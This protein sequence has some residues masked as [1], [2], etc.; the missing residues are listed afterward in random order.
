MAE[1]QQGPAMFFL[2]AWMWLVPILMFVAAVVFGVVAALDGLWGLFG[3]MVFVGVTAIGMLF[4]HWW[5][6]Y[7]FGQTGHVK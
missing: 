2:R 3:F 5:I 6:L 7:R 4:F 1:Q